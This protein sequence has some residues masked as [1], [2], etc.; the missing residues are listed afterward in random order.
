MYRNLDARGNHFLH[1]QPP[2]YDPITETF[3][4]KNK[5][6]IELTTKLGNR[7]HGKRSDPP[8]L[9]PKPKLLTGKSFRPSSFD[10]GKTKVDEHGFSVSFV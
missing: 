5:P 9:P 4:L 10:L 2:L 3:N 6:P 1:H 8:P 7:S